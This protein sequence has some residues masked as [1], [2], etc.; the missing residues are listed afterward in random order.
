M[1]RL[2]KFF[3]S[4]VIFVI[5][6]FFGL[7]WFVNSEV[8]KELSRAVAEIPGLAISYADLSVNILDHA[9]TLSGVDAL[10]PSGQHVQA[11]RL[12]I[13]AFDQ[14]NPVPHFAT[15]TATGLTIPVTPQNF[16]QAADYMKGLGIETLSG[17]GGLDYAFDPATKTLEL[18]DIYLDDPK[19]G[20]ARLSGVVGNVDL[21]GFRPEQFF[22]L[23]INRA[24]LKFSDHT[25]MKLV[26]ADCAKKMGMSETTTLNRISAELDGLTDYAAKQENGPA[27]NAMRGLRR[28]L[29]EPG[30]IIVSATPT[31]PVPV[32][33]FFMG[34]DI[35][36]NLRLLNIKIETD[37]SDGI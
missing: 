25:L 29:N 17:K 1:S 21:V 34:R 14:R 10:L 35:F 7:R 36:E 24:T 2:M 33:Y 9:V 18:K 22:A 6:C 30:S 37:S 4:F 23:G 27:E 26:T 11:D 32:L 31:D 13:L 12:R 28:F 20:V 3:L 15:A 8:D 5:L 19:L 16:G